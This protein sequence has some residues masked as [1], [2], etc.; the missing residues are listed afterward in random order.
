[1]HVAWSYCQAAGFVLLTNEKLKDF[2]K[3]SLLVLKEVQI[4][5]MFKGGFNLC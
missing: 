5:G 1:M 4:N 3:T 2:K